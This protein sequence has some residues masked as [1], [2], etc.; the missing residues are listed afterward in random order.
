MLILSFV[1]KYV[2]IYVYHPK[3]EMMIS[4]YNNYFHDIS[5]SLSYSPLKQNKKNGFHVLPKTL[6]D[7]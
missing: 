7:L 6:L 3:V 2:C 5:I 1:V 4:F